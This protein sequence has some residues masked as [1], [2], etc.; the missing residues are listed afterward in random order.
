M[1]SIRIDVLGIKWRHILIHNHYLTNAIYVRTAFVPHNRVCST[2]SF[3]QKFSCILRTDHTWL[4][5]LKRITLVCAT[6]MRQCG[7]VRCVT[8]SLSTEI[9]LKFIIYCSAINFEAS[10]FCYVNDPSKYVLWLISYSSSQCTRTHHINYFLVGKLESAIGMT[11]WA[12][13][14]SVR[15]CAWA[16]LCERRRTTW[17]LKSFNWKRNI[18][19]HTEYRI[20]NCQPNDMPIIIPG[21]R[22]PSD[23]YGKSSHAII[24]FSSMFPLPFFFCFRQSYDKHHTCAGNE[25][26]ILCMWWNQ[27]ISA[28]IKLSKVCAYFKKCAVANHSSTVIVRRQPST[29]FRAKKAAAKHK[30]KCQSWWSKQKWTNDGGHQN[31]SEAC[32]RWSMLGRGER[33]LLTFRMTS[34]AAMPGY[35]VEPSVTISHIKTPKLQMSDFTEK[36][37]SYSDSIAIHLWNYSDRKMFSD[38]PTIERCVWAAARRQ[39][40][41]ASWE[42]GYSVYKCGDDGRQKHSEKIIS[43]NPPR[44]RTSDRIGLKCRKEKG[45]TMPHQ[46]IQRR[47]DFLSLRLSSSGSFLRNTTDGKITYHKSQSYRSQCEAGIWRTRFEEKECFDEICLVLGVLRQL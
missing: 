46:H 8:T 40:R 29:H 33:R 23:T 20:S 5:S 24:F 12:R 37:L 43:H 6:A 13:T 2:I 41:T 26:R 15:W 18:S 35:G 19:C 31:V 36:I 25:T 30:K 45:A 44:D 14:W 9:R 42:A 3:P 38:E 4:S 28:I 10:Q 11:I 22:V 17:K 7:Q 16:C 27:K 34:A 47:D 21:L 32:I 39:S 1:T